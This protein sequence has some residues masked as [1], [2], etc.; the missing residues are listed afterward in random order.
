MC[1]LR[2]CCEIE[3]GLTDKLVH[4]MS[5][6]RDHISLLLSIVNTFMEKACNHCTQTF[7][8]NE[9]D[10][11]F[12]NKIS[13]VFNH[14]KYLISDPA[15]C[16]TCRQQR[17]LAFRN[18]RNL[19]QRSCSL[20]QKDIISIY[21]SDKSITVYCPSCYWSDQWDPFS[22]GRDFNPNQ[23]FF[24]QFREL[25]NVVPKLGVILIETE[26]SDY[27]NSCG[28]LKNCYLCFDGGNAQ[29][30]LYLE[31][32]N[33]NNDCVDGLCLQQS[34]FCYECSNC[35]N[36]YNVQHCSFSQNCS[37]SYFLMDCSNLKH[38]FGCINLNQKEYFIFNKPYTKEEYERTIQSFHLE[39]FTQREN[40]KIQVNDFFQKFPRRAYRGNQAENCTGNNIVNS[41][42]SFDCFDC[43]DIQDC[44]YCCQLIQTATDCEDVD[45]WGSNTSLVF[46]SSCIGEGAQAILASYYASFGAQRIYH[47]TFCVLGCSDI[48]GCAGLKNHARYAI[49]NK[50]Y[51]AEDYEI[52]AA[53]IAGHMQK[54]GE[55]GE[56]FP[57]QLS[58]FGY[59]ETVA[60]EYYPLSEAIALEKG[61]TWSAY[62]APQ[63]QVK[64]ILTNTELSDSIT[65]VD[66]NILQVA[67]QCSITQRPFR[68]TKPELNFYRTHDIP[69]PRKHPDLRNSQR[70][71]A[72]PPRKL[73]QR[74]CDQCQKKVVTSYAPERPEKILCE[75]CYQLV[76]A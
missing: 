57:S 1:I 44:R 33:S 22:Y 10:N 60:Q 51:S 16:P 27:N 14:K 13:P 20:C 18:E 36:C 73:W 42:N 58:A 66:D 72:K 46:N 5:F 54:T 21:S 47:S 48:F 12:Y 68:I 70:K 75:T 2:T 31:T 45:K 3:S 6:N 29:D 17:R 49:L 7:T 65:D 35:L 4:K 71:E 9:Q 41:Q 62:K 56:F 61:F 32:F 39:N 23:P 8:L 55:F 28:Q 38:C 30:C 11:S 19:Y 34:Q 50:Q 67:I 64:T 74:T 25:F 53:Q 43:K 26:N 37:D 76:I 40:M 69:L 24:D 63:P 15:L 59:N 52:L